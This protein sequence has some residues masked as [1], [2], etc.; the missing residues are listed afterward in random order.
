MLPMVPKVEWLKFFRNKH[1]PTNTRQNYTWKMAKSSAPS[2]LVG[3]KGAK[4][5]IWEYFVF[6]ADDHSVVI[7][8]LKPN[9]AIVHFKLRELTPQKWAK[10]LKN[11]HR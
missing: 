1:T 6:E 7:D 11:S 9:D 10:H 3:E 2:R 4:S 5:R 8:A